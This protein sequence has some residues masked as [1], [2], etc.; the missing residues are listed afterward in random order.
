MAAAKR[1]LIVTP[2]ERI[3]RPTTEEFTELFHELGRE[4]AA[5]ARDDD[6]LHE[7][8]VLVA[9]QG[10]SQVAI[11]I[12]VFHILRFVAHHMSRG[13]AIALTSLHI[14]LTT[15]QAADFLGVSRPFLVKQ[16]EEG[17][18]PYTRTGTHRR[19]QLQDVLA[20][21]ERR[22]RQA[23]KTL[24]ELAREAQEEEDYI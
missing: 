23:L 4:L 11:P 20:Y 8:P 13:D 14:Q 2:Q 17:K 16:I 10:E 22:D 5:L 9:P 3:E 6:G 7:V 1:E 12:S 15:Q 21:K 19:I 18:I 24:A